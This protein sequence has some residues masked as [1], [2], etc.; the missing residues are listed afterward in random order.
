MKV[1]QLCILMELYGGCVEIGLYKTYEIAEKKGKE[2]VKENL[3]YEIIE[4]WIFE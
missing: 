2:L 1:Y 3:K 4:R